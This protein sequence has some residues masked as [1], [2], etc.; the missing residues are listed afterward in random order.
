MFGVRNERLGRI[1]LECVPAMRA[2]A[3]GHYAHGYVFERLWLHLFGL[4][5]IRAGR[6]R[7]GATLPGN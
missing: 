7:V 6:G 5:F 2:L 1:P 3:Q 4:P